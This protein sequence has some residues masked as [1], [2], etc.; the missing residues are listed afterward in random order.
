MGRLSKELNNVRNGLSVLNFKVNN[1]PKLSK[2]GDKCY[3]NYKNNVIG[4]MTITG[5][6][7]KDFTCTTTG[8]KW[9]GKF[10]QRSGPFNSITPIPMKGFRGFRYFTLS[11]SFITK[12][13]NY[14]MKVFI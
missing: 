6:S 3:L 8:K 7:D 13:E 2:V 14:I 12:F 4:W 1:L 5:F 9:S 10:I 11:E